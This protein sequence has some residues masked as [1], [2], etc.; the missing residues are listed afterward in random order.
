[1]GLS[2]ELISQFAK[3]T[4]DSSSKES[5]SNTVR[6]TTVIYN[7]KTYVKFDGSDL[8]TPVTTTSTVSDGDRVTVDIQNHK[9]TITGNATDPSASS[10]VVEKHDS[11]IAEFDIVIAYKVTT[12]DLEAVN[13]TIESLRAKIA[14]I[15]E[16]D[17]L[18][19]EINN[20]QAKFANLEYVKAED[21]EALNA[22]IGNLQAKFGEFG[23]LSVEDLEALNAEIT[24]LKGYTADFTYVS[25]D[26]LSAFRAEIKE[27]SV[28]KLDVTEADIKYAN[29]DFS[30]IGEAAIEYFYA[31]SGLIKDVTVGDGIV[32]GELVG[33]TIK[34]DLI[35]GGTVVADK[36]VIRGEDGLYYKLN[37]LID[38]ITAE[39]LSTEEYQNGLHG[40]S[41]IANTITAEKI[42]V[43]DLV[44]F[45][46]TIGGFKI[47]DNSLYSGVKESIDNT[48][49]GVYMDNTGQIAF[50]DGNEYIKYYRDSEGNYKLEIK[51]ASIKMQSDQTIESVVSDINDKLLTAVKETHHYYIQMLEPPEKPTTFPPEK[52]EDGGEWSEIE[53]EYESG[54]NLYTVT[55]DVFMDDA[56]TYSEVSL[57]GA[58][59][60]AGAA[61]AM[62]NENSANIEGVDNR[63]VISETII[64]QLSDSIS[65]LVTDGNG[66]SLMTQTENGW[67]FSM[68]ETEDTISGITSS[69]NTL[70]QETGNTNATVSALEQAVADLETT[71]EY[72]RIGT[73]ESEPCI[74][75]GESGS[76]YSLMITNTRILFRV[77]S[78]TPTRVTTYGLDTDNISVTGEIR[79]GE[80]IWVRRTNGHYSL[81]WKE[82]SE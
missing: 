11:K 68:K 64:S 19:A 24:N 13:A 33:V 36:L 25:A 2:E 37:S 65:M 42:N 54:T 15:D 59:E 20:L 32:T 60:G 77:G 70:Q 63:L 62:A 16:L 74:E 21:V 39:Q 30:N 5:T 3:I 51:A 41:I 40:E 80:W 56:Y 12:Q 1:M 48:T 38:G 55:C 53:P 46:A 73:W 79:Q 43:H 26:V 34:G 81:M 58:Y 78:S 28:K 14:S 29:I 66:A 17:V 9:A 31:T 27:L 71:A 67:T 57:V 82:V 6:G 4:K 18:N 76:D 44:A 61:Q 23:N 7:G 47:T 69:L 50:G 75:L 52:L 35:E 72:V 49:T 45:D 8:L 10:S 22:M